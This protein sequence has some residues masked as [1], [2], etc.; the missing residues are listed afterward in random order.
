MVTGRTE[1]N[2]LT[3]RPSARARLISLASFLTVVSAVHADNRP[4]VFDYGVDVGVGESDNVTLV[5]SGKISQTIATA[6]ADFSLKQQSRLFDDQI[7]GQFSYF[8]YLQHAFGSQLV[9]RFDGLADFAIIPERLTWAL[10][11]DFGQAQI[12]PFAAQTPTNLESI[13]SLSTGPELNLRFGGA[14][15]AKLN[16]RY[17]RV[18]YQISPFSGNRLLG[19]L[20]VGRLLS[21]RSTVSLNVNSE[22]VLFQNTIVN[23]D[24]N[25]SSAYAG[26]ELHGARTDLTAKLG[27]T[28]VDEGSISTSGALAMLELTRKISPTSSLTFSA[29][30]D[31]TDA[32]A[33]FANLQGGAINQ[34][35][36]AQAIM[37]SSPYTMTFAQMGWRYVRNRTTIGLSARWEI[38]SYING[39]AVDVVGIN[40]L[41]GAIQPGASFAANPATLDMTRG[42]AEFSAEEKITRVLSLQ[43]LGSL[44]SSDYPHA[45]FTAA[46]GS[47][48]FEDGAVG[49]G[50]LFRAGRALEIHLRVE[51]IQRVVSGVESGTGYSDNTAFLTVGYRPRPTTAVPN[52]P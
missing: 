52:A 37:T 13:N 19:S 3:L 11:D 21:A 48:R 50:L 8:D 43:F 10:Q 25:R 17:T 39:S 18:D 9:G 5:S 15:F 31:L 41:S 45:N 32:S 4:V 20:E 36:V 24:F 1:A 42:G 49:A 28:R 44:Y 22:R 14:S 34:I 40:Q 38:D 7:K 2:V 27:V 26:Y 29:G 47:T 33:S 35:A 23:T 16:A 51:H 12:S 46:A 30:R 6:D